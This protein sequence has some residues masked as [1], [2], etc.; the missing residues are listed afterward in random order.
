[1]FQGISNYL[2]ATD[3]EVLDCCVIE[4]ISVCT[5]EPNK[6]NKRASN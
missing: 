2:P 4:E 5:E 6:E 1:M 3:D